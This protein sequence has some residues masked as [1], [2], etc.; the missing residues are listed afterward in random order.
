MT[1]TDEQNMRASLRNLI[2]V[3]A[4]QTG[5]SRYYVARLVQDVAGQLVQQELREGK[6][7]S[8]GTGEPR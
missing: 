1:Y 3:V 2:A 6:S 7:P 5:D 4:K 8:A